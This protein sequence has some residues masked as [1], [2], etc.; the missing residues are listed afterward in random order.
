MRVTA[1]SVSLLQSRK[2]PTIKHVAVLDSD[3]LQRK[4][5]FPHKIEVKKKYLTIV[6]NK[7]NV[8]L[9]QNFN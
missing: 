5:P 8:C 3:V 6:R 7:E 2:F 4:H 1:Q 9:W